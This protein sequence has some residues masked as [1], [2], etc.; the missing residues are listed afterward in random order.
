MTHITIEHHR[1]CGEITVFNNEMNFSL[2]I[3]IGNNKKPS[4]DLSLHINNQQYSQVIFRNEVENISYNI[5][6]VR[7]YLRKAVRALVDYYYTLGLGDE[8]YVKIA[9]ENYINILKL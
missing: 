7:Q 2:T 4:F 6:E 3:E 5:S 1:S 8:E 9:V